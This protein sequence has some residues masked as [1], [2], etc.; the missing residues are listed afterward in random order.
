MP[1]LREPQG[2][3]NVGEFPLLEALIGRRSR[4]FGL[5][6]TL[7]EGPLAFESSAA[8]LPLSELETTLV[9]AAAG[10]NTGWHFLIK[11]SETAGPGLPGYPVGAERRTCPSAADGRVDL[12]R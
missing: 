12:H 2:L 11:R 10:G 7:P 9:V 5:G 1:G 4:R 6:Y 8:P 3:K